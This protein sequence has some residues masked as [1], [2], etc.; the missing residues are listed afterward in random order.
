MPTEKKEKAVESLQEVFSR[1]NIGI[2]TDYRGLKTSD[3]NELR[4]KLRE[5]DAEYKVVKNSLA[6]I[7]ARNVGLEHLGSTFEG[8]VAV[9]FGYGDVIKTAKTLTDYIR[10]SKSTMNIKGGFLQDRVLSAI[11]VDT[12]AR[13]P[14]RE[15]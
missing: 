4:R 10:I 14:S 13:L 6:Q 5:A 2:L 12:L 1:C 3:L 9:A 7:A 8:P 11:E 15:I